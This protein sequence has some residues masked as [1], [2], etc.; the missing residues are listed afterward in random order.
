MQRPT[1]DAEK[2]ARAAVAVQSRAEVEAAIRTGVRSRSGPPAR[3][4]GRGI[5]APFTT[6]EIRKQA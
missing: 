1:M 6:I 2:A 5:A 3:S 4:L